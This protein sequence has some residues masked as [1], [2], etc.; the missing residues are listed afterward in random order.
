MEKA[1]LRRRCAFAIRRQGWYGWTLVGGGVRL[2][3]RFYRAFVGQPCYGTEVELWRDGKAK[4]ASLNVRILGQATWSN[5]HRQ[6]VSWADMA[7]Q[8]KVIAMIG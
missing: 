4:N 6:P 8:V 1:K 3:E 2:Q 7:G 5:P